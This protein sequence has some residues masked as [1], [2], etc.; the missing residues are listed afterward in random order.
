ML[1]LLDFF[2]HTGRAKATQVLLERAEA[3][4][5]PP[6]DYLGLQENEADALGDL[7]TIFPQVRTPCHEF[8]LDFTLQDGIKDDIHPRE[9]VLAMPSLQDLCQGLQD[10]TDS[11]H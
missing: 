10:T 2:L 5:I 4:L 9:Q 3:S 8:V 11:E 1:L 6:L 7:D